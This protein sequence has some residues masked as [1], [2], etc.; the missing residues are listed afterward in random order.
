MV[1]LKAAVQEARPILIPAVALA[2]VWR[3]GSRSARLARLRSSCAIDPLDERL[4][5]AAGVLCGRCGTT[6]AIDAAV[7][8]SAA[9]RADAVLTSDPDDLQPLASVTGRARIVDIASLP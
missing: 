5:K 3:G 2:Q 4:A 7:V 6:D 9:R 1:F 8:V